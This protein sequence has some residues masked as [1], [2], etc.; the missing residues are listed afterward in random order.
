MALA[1][2]ARG[3]EQKVKGTPQPWIAFGADTAL[4]LLPPW[5]KAPMMFSVGY[6]QKK[7]ESEDSDPA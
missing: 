3:G 7:A 4:F 1:G 5:V 2:A 6:P